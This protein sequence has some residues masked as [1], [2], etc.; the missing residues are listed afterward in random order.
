[1]TVLSY[2]GGKRIIPTLESCKLQTHKDKELIISDDASPDGITPK[3]IEDWLSENEHFFKKVV[4]IKN[5]VN[6]GI[7]KNSRNAAIH[8][9]GVII[10]PIGQGD[11]IYGPETIERIS[12]E[13]EK[14]R[15]EGLREPYLWLGHFQSFVMKNGTKANHHFPMSTKKDFDLIEG[16]PDKFLRKMLRKNF[17]GAPSFIYNAKYFDDDIFPLPEIIRHI[18]DYPCTLWNLINK[19][20]IGIIRQFIRWYEF[21]IGMSRNPDS[22][23]KKEK[24]T[25]FQWLDNL[26]PDIEIKKRQDYKFNCKNHWQRMTRH[27]LIFTSDALEYIAWEFTEALS[28]TQR[29]PVKVEKESS[30]PFD[31]KIFSSQYYPE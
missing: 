18:D 8:A 11:L 5:Q 9:T 26:F 31:E 29:W 16:Y 22:K 4:F 15:L 13:I 12:H 21:G 30:L 17:I 14:Q 3:I 28:L 6:T 7:A 27:P 1:M 24:E 20:R 19:H 23:Y 25:I 2:N 10:F